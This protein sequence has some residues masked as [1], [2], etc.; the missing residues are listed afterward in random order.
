ML[1]AVEYEQHQQREQFRQPKRGGCEGDVFQAVDEQQADGGEREH[2]AEI[3]HRRRNTA[4]AGETEKRQ[5][6]GELGDTDVVARAVHLRRRV[7]AH[8]GEGFVNQA[9]HEVRFPLACAAVL[10]Q[11]RQPVEQVAGVDHQGEKQRVYRIERG[12]EQRQSD[13]LHR[14]GE[15]TGCTE[16]PTAGRIRGSTSAAHRPCRA[17]QTPPVRAVFS[18]RR[19]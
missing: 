5:H 9:K 11:H 6:A 15:H 4:A 12:G 13:V 2:V 3:V 16:P 19:F 10:P 14:S 18:E 7:A 8:D 1:P 17:P